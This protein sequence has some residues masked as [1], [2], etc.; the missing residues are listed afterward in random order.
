MSYG[1]S[2]LANLFPQFFRSQPSKSKSIEPDE[3]ESRVTPSEK[4]QRGRD[5]ICDAVVELLEASKT[6]MSHAE[7]VNQ[8]GIQSDFEGKSQ[9]YLSWSVLG[10]LVNQGRIKYVGSRHTRLY[11][12]RPAQLTSDER[13]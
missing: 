2:K 12:L 1:V 6:A 10:I 13:L 7:I 8:L 3:T 11:Y 4:A 5:L 9:N